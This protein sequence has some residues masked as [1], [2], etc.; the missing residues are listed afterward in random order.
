VGRRTLQPKAL[1][2]AARVI[3]WLKLCGRTLEWVPCLSTFSSWEFAGT[4]MVA[5]R[6]RID[7]WLSLRTPSDCT[8]RV[9][10]TDDV[11]KTRAK[12]PLRAKLRFVPRTTVTAGPRSRVEMNAQWAL[13]TACLP[14]S[15]SWAHYRIDRLYRHHRQNDISKPRGKPWR[16]PALIRYCASNSRSSDESVVSSRIG[17]PSC[18]SRA[19]SMVAVVPVLSK[20]TR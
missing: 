16:S 7:G 13:L 4:I 18:R 5:I 6:D 11:K 9:L 15:V 2:K 3:L 1:C 17:R 19:P 14:P 8:T 20:V 10:V 12:A